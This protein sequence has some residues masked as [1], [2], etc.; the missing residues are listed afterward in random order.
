MDYRE[1]VRDHV[2]WLVNV[3]QFLTRPETVGLFTRANGMARP[4]RIESVADSAAVP[5]GEVWDTQTWPDDVWNKPL[6]ASWKDE[7]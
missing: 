4:G 3:S 7:C 5:E 2:K 1:T 6:G